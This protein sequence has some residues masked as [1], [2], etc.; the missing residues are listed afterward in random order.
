MSWPGPV[1]AR[2]QHALGERHPDRVREA[3]AERPGGHLDAR[4][5]PALGMS[6]RARAPLPELLQILDREV[7]AAK[8]QARVEQHRGVAAREHETVA[9]RPVR[10]RRV[11]AEMAGEQPIGERGEAHGRAGMARFRPLDGIDREKADGVDRLALDAT[12][13][14]HGSGPLHD[15]EIVA[16]TIRPGRHEAPSPAVPDRAAPW[17][18]AH[19]ALS[20]RGDRR[21]AGA[22]IP[23]H[24]PA[25][26]R[27]EPDLTDWRRE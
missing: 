11:V 16:D 1:E 12:R 20:A 6:G 2:G 9:I 8:M 4:R 14:R 22:P 26:G 15:H 5:H 23:R 27:S 19:G 24:A 17:H 10:C 13:R 18:G 25:P 21:S 3:L 7:V